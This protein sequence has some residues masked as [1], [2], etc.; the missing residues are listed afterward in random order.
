MEVL[1]ELLVAEL[2]AVAVRLVLAHVLDWIRG[3]S[4][5]RVRPGFLSA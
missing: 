2:L 3:P 1:L 4:G 5:A